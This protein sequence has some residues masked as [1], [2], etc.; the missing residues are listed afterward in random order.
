MV[1]WNKSL[2]AQLKHQQAVLEEAKKAA[3]NPNYKPI[4][5]IGKRFKNLFEQQVSDSNFR[6]KR[7]NRKNKNV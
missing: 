3:N 1:S 7:Q 6:N 5:K 2:D 4:M